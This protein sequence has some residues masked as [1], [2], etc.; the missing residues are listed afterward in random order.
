MSRD[1]SEL[2]KRIV[3]ATLS[4]LNRTPLYVAKYPVGIDACVQYLGSLAN[5]E[6]NDVGVIGIHGTGGIGKTTVPKALCNNFADDFEGS[7]FL[8]NVRETSQQY[9]GLV[10][11]QETLLFDML[12]DQNLKV[13]STH[14]RINI[15]RER[16]CHKSVL[17]ILDNV[18]QLDQLETLAGGQ[19]WFG[20]GSRVI[21]T[22]KMST[23]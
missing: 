6:A 11:L 7:S 1:E 2:I 20:P 4:K 18:D 9:Y 15:I 13:G 17:L 8:A 16:L 19:D 23:S 14:R 3:E 10:Q 5:V 12:G 22:A 21:I